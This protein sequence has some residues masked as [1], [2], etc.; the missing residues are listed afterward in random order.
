MRT[1]KGIEVFS[2]LGAAQEAAISALLGSLASSSLAAAAPV[3][4]VTCVT[5]PS[6]IADNAREGHKDLR[7]LT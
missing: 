7:T 4:P 1:G 6:D 5:E 3:K 2:L